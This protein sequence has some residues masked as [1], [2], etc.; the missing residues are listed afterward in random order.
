MSRSTPHDSIREVVQNSVL[1]SIIPA[2]S[3]AE[4]C[5]KPYPTFMR[6]INPYDKNAKLGIETFFELIKVTEDIEPLEF[7]ARHLG[8][9]LVPIDE[10]ETP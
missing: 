1:N 7:M 3:L 4:A 5:G 8:Y 6:E 9:R 10:E 2:K